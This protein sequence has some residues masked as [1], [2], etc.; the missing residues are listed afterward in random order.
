MA[1]DWTYS[2]NSCGYM[3]YYK[4][5]AIMGAASGGTVTHTADGRVR[6][7]RHR[8]A[9][10]KMYAQQAQA[11]CARLNKAGAVPEEIGGP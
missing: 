5:K 10:V 4:D 1:N 8:V 3:L 6:H 9:D 2:S 11:E 7:W